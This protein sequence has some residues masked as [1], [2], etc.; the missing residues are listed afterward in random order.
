[1]SFFEF[2]P[3]I[4]PIIAIL[5]FIKA[6]IEWRRSQLWKESEFLSKEMKEFFSDEKIKIVLTL[7]DW[8][9]RK[10]K[11]GDT[12]VKVSDK[13]LV[14]SLKT[15]KEKSNFSPEEAYIRDLFDYFFDKLS[16]LKI[17]CKNGL[18][19]EKKLFNYLEYY[20]DILT[21]PGRKPKELLNI[22]D[23]YIKYY[24]FKNV[25]DLLNNWKKTKPTK[26]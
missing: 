13:F 14:E 6:I 21:I 3:Q 2:I 23:N 22:I 24:H 5:S 7:L 25:S 8:N 10:V 17:H 16:H 12:Q 15:H 9:V 4:L 18:V 11:I 1:M 20:L 19:S 26:Q